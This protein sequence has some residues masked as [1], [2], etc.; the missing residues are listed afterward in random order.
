MNYKT[1]FSERKTY[2][3]V[4]YNRYQRKQVVFETIKGWTFLSPLLIVALIFSTA[5]IAYA[6]YFSLHK[7]TAADHTFVGLE[8]W[9][10][11]F[12]G[13]IGLGKVIKNTFLF[14]FISVPLILF[15]TIIL[16]SIVNSKFVKNKKTFLTIF[17]LPQVTSAIAATL[18]FRNMVGPEQVI[19]IDYILDPKKAIWLLVMITT[20]GGVAGNLITI[21][22][23]FS[24]IDTNQYE[25]A[26]LDGA[27]P[28]QKIFR[29]TLPSIMPV[30][31]YSLFM[32]MVG[33]FG[34]FAQPYMLAGIGVS[35]EYIYTIV[36]KAYDL[37]IPVSPGSL[38]NIGL[39]IAMMFFAAMMMALLST[40]ANTIAPLNKRSI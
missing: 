35:K 19:D 15:I 37:I 33:A 39:G 34:I 5:S 22:T 12:S 16:A 38:P 27:S 8:N 40:I 7:G 31:A 25:A 24:T 18:V 17:F 4:K 6:L 3:Y 29:I 14:T 32:A 2:E 20:W 21:N 10:T 11:L 28:F 1:V 23:A 36:A 13:E 26:E 9:K 30:V